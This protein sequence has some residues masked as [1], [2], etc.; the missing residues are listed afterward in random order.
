MKFH[1]ASFPLGCW[2]ATSTRR[3]VVVAHHKCKKVSS[4]LQLNKVEEQLDTNFAPS[5]WFLA[6]LLLF[7]TI[8]SSA[9]NFLA[10]ARGVLQISFGKE[11]RKL[12]STT[13]IRRSN[14]SGNWAQFLNKESLKKKKMKP[15]YSVNHF[16]PDNNFK[17]KTLPLPVFHYTDISRQDNRDCSIYESNTNTLCPAPQY[18]LL[19]SSKASPSSLSIFSLIQNNKPCSPLGGTGCK[20]PPMGFR[21]TAVSGNS[22][23]FQNQ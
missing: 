5:E 11:L 14:L 9:G 2:D 16:A 21:V 4:I 18:S 1:L 20:K 17:N 13:A 15:F 10:H 22:G 19:V 6:G 7:L 3:A 23:Y 12:R 8:F